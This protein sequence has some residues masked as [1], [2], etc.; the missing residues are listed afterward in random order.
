MFFDVPRDFKVAVVIQ[1]VMDIAVNDPLDRQKSPVV[2]CDMRHEA[3]VGSEP[4]PAHSSAIV[5]RMAVEIKTTTRWI[6]ADFKWTGRSIWTVQT[7]PH[8]YG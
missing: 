2:R 4:L 8:L 7:G 3:G 6:V 5:I 1:N